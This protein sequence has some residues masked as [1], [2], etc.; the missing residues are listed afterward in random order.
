MGKF[1]GNPR[2]HVLSIRVTDDEKAVLN[3]LNEIMR[4]TLKSTS[5]VIREVMT[6]YTSSFMVVSANRGKH[7]S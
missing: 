5:T 1:K 6:I 3:V 4:H 2:Y 7:L